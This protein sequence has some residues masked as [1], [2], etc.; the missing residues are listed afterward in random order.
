MFFDWLARVNGIYVNS[1]KKWSPNDA[2]N[3]LFRGL[4]KN[5]KKGRKKESEK[6]KV[7]ILRENTYV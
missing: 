5:L 1:A 6:N 3:N 4:R 7:N 2:N